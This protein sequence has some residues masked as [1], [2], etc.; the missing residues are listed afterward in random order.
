[1][2][3]LLALAARTFAQTPRNALAYLAAAAKRTEVV[4]KAGARMLELGLNS[5]ATRALMERLAAAL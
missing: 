1:M 3:A 4:R 5:R 2:R